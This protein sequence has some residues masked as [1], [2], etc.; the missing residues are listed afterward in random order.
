[1]PAGSRAGAAGLGE[2]NEG[3][4]APEP[5]ESMRRNFQRPVRHFGRG[6]E[7]LCPE[8]AIDAGR[9]DV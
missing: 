6:F 9:F 8:I 7:P 3:A 4:F 2:R 5:R 1:M